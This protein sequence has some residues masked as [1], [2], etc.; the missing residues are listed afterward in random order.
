VPKHRDND[1]KLATCLEK[2]MLKRHIILRLQT[3]ASAEDV[4]ESTSLL[5]KRIDNGRSVRHQRRLEHVR[6]DAQDGVESAVLA[7]VR[8]PGHAGHELGDEDEIDDQR[9]GEEGVLADVEEA[10]EC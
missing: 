7:A 9:G 2:L 5:G 1:V 6:Q 3:H 8:L 10:G 4:R